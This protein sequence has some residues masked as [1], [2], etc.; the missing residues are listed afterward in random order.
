MLPPCAN[1]AQVWYSARQPVCRSH[2]HIVD[3]AFQKIKAGS[4]SRQ[5]HT[6][7][8]VMPHYS[9]ETSKATH[10]HTEMACRAEPRPMTA[11]AG[12]WRQQAL[13]VFWKRFK[14][15]LRVAHGCHPFAKVAKRCIKN[16]SKNYIVA[17]EQENPCTAW[18]CNPAYGIWNKPS[19]LGKCVCRVQTLFVKRIKVF[20]DWACCCIQS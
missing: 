9:K 1:K 20:L 5:D 16:I 17:K 4:L 11:S 19:G 18:D 15:E 7:I 8:A 2:W 10:T 14:P 6:K 3:I 13:K 12:P